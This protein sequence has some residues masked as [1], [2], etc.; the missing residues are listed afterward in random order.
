MRRAL[1]PTGALVAE[2]KELA[3]KRAENLVGTEAKSLRPSVSNRRSITRDTVRVRLSWYLDG[4]AGRQTLKQIGSHTSSSRGVGQT[5]PEIG[6]HQPRSSSG[7]GEGSPNADAPA[8]T[9]SPSESGTCCSVH[10]RGGHS[11]VE[12]RVRH[13]EVWSA[14][15]SAER[16]SHHEKATHHPMECHASSASLREWSVNY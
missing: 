14:S 2:I 10:C 11:G 7:R 5:S 3:R 15:P 6:K 9:F 12:S 1:E 8:T 16:G 4:T 13:I